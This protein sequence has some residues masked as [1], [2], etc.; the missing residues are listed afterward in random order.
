MKHTIFTPLSRLLP[1]VAA[2]SLALLCAACTQDEVPAGGDETTQGADAVPLRIASVSVQPQAE[3]QTRAATALQ[4]EG[5]Q[6]GIF[7][8]PYRGNGVVTLPNV[9]YTYTAA[10]GWQPTDPANPVYLLNKESDIIAY[11]PYD[12]AN[13]R[14]SITLHSEGVI[15]DHYNTGYGTCG[16]D[17]CLAS[18]QTVTNATPPITFPM[19]HK[20]AMVQV[21]FTKDPTYV[22]T[23]SLKVREIIIGNAAMVAS[24]TID[25]TTGTIT[26][27]QLGYAMWASNSMLE[28]TENAGQEPKSWAYLSVVPTPDDLSLTDN[29]RFRIRVDQPGTEPVVSSASYPVSMLPDTRFEA[30]K[31]YQF[32][33]NMKPGVVEVKSV[34]VFDWEPGTEIPA[35]EVTK[36]ATDYIEVA[37]TKWSKNYLVI[38]NYTAKEP[39]IA[40]T[41]S[42]FTY[43]S[44]ENG[45]FIVQYYTVTTISLGTDPCSKIKPLDEWTLPTEEQIKALRSVRRVNRNGT[46]YFETETPNPELY[47]ER[48]FYLSLGNIVAKKIDG[49]DPVCFL[50]FPNETNT[51]GYDIQGPKVTTTGNKIRCVKAEKPVIQP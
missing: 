41:P 48:Y 32:I 19:K 28:V 49:S 1:V 10:N 34:K 16:V 39:E 38:H 43:F 47:P 35:M 7:R 24:A 6:I 21:G 23:Q 11:Y 20:M 3:T 5:G 31:L 8:L 14:T 30:G 40:D 25:I 45:S 50:I 18:P 2:A 42:A 36:P 51:G 22:T 33:F 13:S 29:L 12:A 37:G 26:E 4:Q 46:M 17:F 44:W 9:P 15:K 27:P